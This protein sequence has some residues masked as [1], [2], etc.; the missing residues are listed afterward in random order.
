VGAGCGCKL[1]AA[2]LLPIVGGLPVQSDE[3]LLV[4]T[5]TGDDAAVFRIGDTRRPASPKATATALATVVFPTPPLPVKNTNGVSH[6]VHAN[7][8][9]SPGPVTSLQR[10]HVTDQLQETSHYPAAAP[11]WHF[12]LS[13]LGW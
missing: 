11:G 13:R 12:G 10:Q 7:G 2:E 4:G 6:D 9:R 5:A 1:P 8:R 3:R